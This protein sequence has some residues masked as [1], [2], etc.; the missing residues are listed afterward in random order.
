MQTYLSMY[1]YNLEDIRVVFQF[2]Q[3]SR[4]NDAYPLTGNIEFYVIPILQGIWNTDHME[5][6]VTP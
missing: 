6:S 1:L 4:G 5:G 2:Y 3:Y